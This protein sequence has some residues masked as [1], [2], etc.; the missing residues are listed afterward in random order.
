MQAKIINSK[1]ANI[2]Y[3]LNLRLMDFLITFFSKYKLLFFF[4]VLL[5][6]NEM[7]FKIVSDEEIR[8][9]ELQLDL[10]ELKITGAG[11]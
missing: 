8:K 3:I 1:Q 2:K 7:T 9:A 6:I 10:N 5:Q 11:H 4:F